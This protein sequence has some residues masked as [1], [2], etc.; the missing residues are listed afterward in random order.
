MT[1]V[2]QEIIDQVRRE[3]KAALVQLC[4]LEKGT[5]FV[6]AALQLHTV[7]YDRYGIFKMNVTRIGVQPIDTV[8]PPDY[9]H[10]FGFMSDPVNAT[11]QEVAEA[12]RVI[13]KWPAIEQL[14]GD[15]RVMLTD[16]SDI[17]PTILDYY[18]PDFEEFIHGDSSRES[19]S[20]PM[21]SDME[22]A[23][24]KGVVASVIHQYKDKWSLPISSKKQLPDDILGPL[25]AE[26]E[27]HF[28]RVVKRLQSVYKDDDEE[29][30]ILERRIKEIRQTKLDYRRMVEDLTG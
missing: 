5:P 22:A 21:R 2:S 13:L 15:H 16:M 10:G 1:Q 25:L 7:F 28:D 4:Q 24:R 3:L 19:G 6:P 11:P 26:M 9:R 30:A 20:P 14:N 18:L 12:I 8:L 23:V 29:I 27:Q 17:L